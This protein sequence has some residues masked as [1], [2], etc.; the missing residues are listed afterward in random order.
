MNESDRRSLWAELPEHLGP[1]PSPDDREFWAGAARGELR[2]QRCGACGLHQHYGR[3]ACSHCGAP[4]VEWVTASGT[5][6]IHSYTVIRQHGAR[7]FR[8]AVPFV[9]ALVD[10]DEAGARVLGAMPGVAPDE[11]TIGAAVRATFRRTA[12]AE[13]GVVDFAF[14]AP[15]T[16]T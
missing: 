8:D 2:V 15:P 13:L 6:T 16:G 3:I 10:L 4:E 5:G 14:V 1:W 12:D 7:P 9:V 11:V